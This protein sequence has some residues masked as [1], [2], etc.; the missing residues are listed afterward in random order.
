MIDRSDERRI[1]NAAN[2]LSVMGGTTQKDSAA[3]WMVAEF[4]TRELAWEYYCW[5]TAYKYFA[6]TPSSSPDSPLFYVAFRV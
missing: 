4:N 2:K 5:L 1:I 6:L 3:G